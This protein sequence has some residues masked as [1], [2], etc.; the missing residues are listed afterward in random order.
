MKPSSSI[1]LL[2]VT[3][4]FQ[5]LS[6]ASAVR[7]VRF[8]SPL[9]SLTIPDPELL[10]KA[11]DA[12]SDGQGALE[13]PRRKFLPRFVAG[14]K[15]E[16]T[17]RQRL[18]VGEIKVK[19]DEVLE[20]D[21]SGKDWVGQAKVAE[22]R[23]RRKEDSIIEKGYDAAIARYE[24]SSA[25][26]AAS[27]PKA[28]NP[29][30]YQFVG[31][32]DKSNPKKPIKWHARPKPAGAKWSIRLVHVNKD[33]IIKDLFDRGKVDIFAKYTNTGKMETKGEGDADKPTN[34]PIVTSKYE[35]RKRSWKTLFN[36]SPKHFITDS[37]GAYWR[38]RRL[39]PG[40]YTDGE[41]VYEASYRFRDGRNGMHKV[42]TLK[43]FL[44][45]RA[46]DKKEKDGI[47]KKLREDPPDVVLEL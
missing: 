44:S 47:L 2:G 20:A 45:S 3:L 13:T 28:K 42:S 26:S 19:D 5:L 32:I 31:L 25:A 4:L 10:D 46:V 14:L 27:T 15:A 39:R 21:V 41:T 29:N 24:S 35:V 23:H 18:A 16:D 38:E 7:E 34:V 11:P 33:A 40:M 8:V 6:G 12:S 30:K 1:Y 9:Q 43:Q 37:S 36:F 17:M 22:E